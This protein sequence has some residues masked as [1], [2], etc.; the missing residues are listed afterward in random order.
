M[1][2][3][4]F[5]MRKL[6]YLKDLFALNTYLN[7]NE[8][9]AIDSKVKETLISC[10]YES[11]VLNTSGLYDSDTR[12][13]SILDLYSY[14]KNIDTT[15]RV[16]ITDEVI[17][18]IEAISSDNAFIGDDLSLKDVLLKIRNYRNRLFAHSD[19]AYI[20]S[21]AESFDGIPIYRF[22]FLYLLM[23]DIVIYIDKIYNLGLNPFYLKENLKF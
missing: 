8:S 3:M 19:K 2:T 23:V 1:F 14:D 11:I 10:C 15:K 6:E 12:G 18:W 16:E 17:A 7:S 5:L 9:M 22:W 4:N 13:Y 21:L 20:K